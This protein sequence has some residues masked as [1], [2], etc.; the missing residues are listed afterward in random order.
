MFLYVFDKLVDRNL[1]LL[2]DSA[3]SPDSK[4]TVERHNTAHRSL[5]GF[6]FEDYVAPSLPN[7]PE[8]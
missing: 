7:L 4:F 6:F 5:G 1:C 3:E 8:S 2:Q